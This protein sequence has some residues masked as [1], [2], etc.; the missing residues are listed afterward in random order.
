M[1]NNSTR[2]SKSELSHYGHYGTQSV[3]LSKDSQQ[4]FDQCGICLHVL[5]EPMACRKGHMFC[6]HCIYQ[7]LLDQKKANKK[8]LKK[9]QEA[10][11]LESEREILKR[12]SEAQEKLAAFT[13]QESSLIVSRTSD[14][15]AKAVEQTSTK[16][17]WLPEE[18]PS[19]SSSAGAKP[20]QDTI[21]LRGGHSLRLKDLVAVDFKSLKPE[22]PAKDDE[23]LSAPKLSSDWICYMCNK[24]LKS[25][26]KVVLIRVCG[27]AIC[28]KCSDEFAKKNCP[29]CDRLCD[30]PNEKIVL[31]PPASSFA[32]GGSTI[33]SISTP[34][35]RIM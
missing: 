3:R 35:P 23:D 17:W 14:S 34:A 22:Q 12:H 7:N 8:K 2:I 30:E 6:K 19:H 1:H 27:H 25:I 15:Q 20:S 9:W 28:H 33:A 16:S 31:Q 26:S 21:C 10:N 32:E 29:V 5:V 13:Q 18:A 11:K 4:Q 24:D